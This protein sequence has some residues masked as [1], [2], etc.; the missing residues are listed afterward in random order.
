MHDGNAVSR[1]TKALL[2]R[3][4][5]LLTRW[6]AR[7][8]LVAR[9]T[10]PDLRTRHIADSLQLAD[11]GSLDA[12]WTDLGSGGGLPG[13]VLA[14]AMT[15]EGARGHVTCIESDRRK[16]AFLTTVAQEL[17]LPM[18][19]IAARAE[20]ASPTESGVV[21]ARALAA[22]PQLLS[23]AQRH[24]AEHAICLFPKGKT[25]REELEAARATWHFSCDV[26]P[27]ATDPEA[28]ILKIGDLV[29]ATDA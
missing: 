28:V 4:A 13:A 16:C 1:E 26:R 6:T 10:V 24:M 25:W 11:H 22:L 17:G 2:D 27:S 7:V 15:G 3:Y 23:Y 21:T 29:R 20:A 14:A 8:N 12:H 9:G 19:V 18:T 5:E